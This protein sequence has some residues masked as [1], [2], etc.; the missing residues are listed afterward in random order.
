MGSNQKERIVSNCTIWLRLRED[1][2]VY[3]LS[4]PR[5]ICTMWAVKYDVYFRTIKN[6]LLDKK[7]SCCYPTSPWHEDE[8]DYDTIYGLNRVSF[9]SYICL[10]SFIHPSLLPIHSS[11][12]NLSF[13]S[14][15]LS[16]QPS[17]LSFIAIQTSNAKPTLPR[18]NARATLSLN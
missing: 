9:F 6:V 4:Q 8:A 2:H 18:S 16:S 1:M 17:I 11:F 10:T 3:V 15:L 13:L 14:H 5:I 12:L 7:V